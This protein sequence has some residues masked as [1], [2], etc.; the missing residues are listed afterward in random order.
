MTSSV[1]WNFAGQRVLVTGAASGLGLAIAAAFAAAG[2]QVVL[3]GRDRTALDAAAQTLRQTA[4][5]DP[6]A[7]VCD[8]ASRPGIIRAA[9][10][11]IQTLGGIDILVN[12]AG[13]GGSSALTDLT[14]ADLDLQI[15]VNL[16]ATIVMTRE[17]IRGM[18]DRESGVIINISSQAAKKGFAGITHYSASKAG[19]LGFTMSL[20]AEVAPT[21]R[22]NAVCPGMVL[23][24]MMEQNI[25]QTMA[26]KALSWDDAYS[27]WTAGIPMGHMQQPEDVANAVLFLASGGARE[28]T[29]EAL[30]VSGG[31]TTD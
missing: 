3:L 29:G 12:N 7:V 4:I 27:E 13:V 26:D 18:L 6:T 16:V 11:V 23:T 28:I 10:E 25:Q 9:Q 5:S 31:Q 17:L 30:N 20:A 21:I 19:V 1:Q 15:D 22:V 8:L 14:D 24:P 2:A